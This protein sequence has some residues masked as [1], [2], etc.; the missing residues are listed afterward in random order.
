MPRYSYVVAFPILIAICVG[1]NIQR[2]PTVSAMLRGESVESRWLGRSEV[3]DFQAKPT[4]ESKSYQGYRSD[5]DRVTDSRASR[6]PIPLSDSLSSSAHSTSSSQSF[7]SSQSISPSRSTP[8]SQPGTASTSTNSST[9]TSSTEHDNGSNGSDFYKSRSGNT[10]ST[11]TTGVSSTSGSSPRSSSTGSSSYGYDNYSNDSNSYESRPYSNS[12]NSLTDTYSSSDPYNNSSRSDSYNGSYGSSY[13]ASPASSWYDNR[14]NYDQPEDRNGNTNSTENRS[15]SRTPS[16]NR[17]SR[18]VDYGNESIW[19]SSGNNTYR[20]DSPLPGYS[21]RYPAADVE[22]EA[23]STSSTPATS[24]NTVT[25][26]ATATLAEMESAAPQS[27]RPLSLQEKH[28]LRLATPFSFS[29]TASQ[30]A[31]GQY[32]PPDF[33]P[34]HENGVVRKLIN[35]STEPAVTISP[36]TFVSVTTPDTTSSLSPE[37]VMTSHES[38]GDGGTLP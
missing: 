30:D 31:S 3:F 36:V 6:T 12:S 2:Y 26:N 27:L 7:T 23:T 32:I 10:G 15:E 33:L 29:P 38:E 16:D 9:S 13:S 35:P 11:V 37:T 21:N 22:E 4:G 1:V 17:Y 34:P 25:S 18:P 28:E 5:S 8:V 24:M 14:N 19:G 20:M